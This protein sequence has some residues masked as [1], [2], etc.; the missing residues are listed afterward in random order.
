MEGGQEREGD[1]KKSKRR[2]KR[3]Q[4]IIQWHVLV[5]G[6]RERERERQTDRQTDRDRGPV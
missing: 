2:R 3:G 5:Q 6:D 4:E 1:G